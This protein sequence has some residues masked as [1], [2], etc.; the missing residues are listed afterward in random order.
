MVKIETFKRIDD[1]E[2]EVYYVHAVS[3]W[4]LRVNGRLMGYIEEPTIEAAKRRL[5]REL[6]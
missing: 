5:L 3:R 1:T 2:F 6:L 4:M